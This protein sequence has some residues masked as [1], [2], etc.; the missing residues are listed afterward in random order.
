M[1]RPARHASTLGRKHPATNKV[2]K[3]QAPLPEDTWNPPGALRKCRKT[4][5]AGV[6][7]E[8]LLP[9]IPPESPIQAARL[10]YFPEHRLFHPQS[11]HIDIADAG[12]R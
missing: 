10:Q 1:S 11:E 2:A 12:L 9:V 7:C 6:A 5:C 3:F 8:P 4:R